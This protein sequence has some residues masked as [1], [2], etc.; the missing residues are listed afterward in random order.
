VTTT[1]TPPVA[2]PDPASGPQPSR[3]VQAK[4][5]VH[6]TSNQYCCIRYRMPWHSMVRHYTHCSRLGWRRWSWH[7]P[8]GHSA[9]VPMAWYMKMK[10]S[11][12]GEGGVWKRTSGV[13]PRTVTYQTRLVYHEPS[14]TVKWWP[15]AQQA[16]LPSSPA[17]Q[18]IANP[19]PT[20]DSACNPQ[21]QQHT[22][23]T[24]VWCSRCP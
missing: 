16:I 18:R 7:S 13:V 12:G 20:P 19:P 21:Q 11:R 8:R 17:A 10:Q 4:R 6:P 14:G 9:Q 5:S 22:T 2:I 15:R 3:I 1:L 24:K 23:R